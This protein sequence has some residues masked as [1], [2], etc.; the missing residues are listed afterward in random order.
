MQVALFTCVI[1]FLAS[2]IFISD[3]GFAMLD[4]FD[5]YILNFALMLTGALEAY[6][7]AWVWGWQE[8]RYRCGFKCVPI[9]MLLSALSTGFPGPWSASHCSV[10]C[11]WA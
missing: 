9:T 2:I 4:V 6:V 1:G 11:V 8:I 10:V 3:I 5:H 7:V